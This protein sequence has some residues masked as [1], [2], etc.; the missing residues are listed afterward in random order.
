MRRL[1]FD[2][3]DC[4]IEWVLCFLCVYACLELYGGWR[5][6]PSRMEDAD[7]VADVLSF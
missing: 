1:I 4:F 5:I 2:D 7:V 3:G 6:V